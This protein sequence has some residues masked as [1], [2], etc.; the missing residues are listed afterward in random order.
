MLIEKLSLVE[1]KYGDLRGT[2]GSTKEKNLDTQ[3]S[4]D[5]VTGAAFNKFD[6]AILVSSDGDYLSAVE[7]VKKFN[8][9][10]E[11]LFFRDSISMNL[12]K[13]CDI[14][15]RARRSYFQPLEFKKD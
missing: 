6:T 12:K 15:R 3:L 2:K 7:N 10:V 5:L 14:T 11:L 9:K 13:S 4:I 8:K 1:V